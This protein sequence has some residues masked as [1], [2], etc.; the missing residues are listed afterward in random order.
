MTG[1]RNGPYDL[2]RIS[3]Q[4]ITGRLVRLIPALGTLPEGQVRPGFSVTVDAISHTAAI[5]VIDA[6]VRTSIG[7]D[8]DS[9]HI[10]ADSP[11]R[12]PSWG[13]VRRLDGARAHN[14]VREETRHSRRTKDTGVGPGVVFNPEPDPAWRTR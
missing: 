13:V 11:I 14:P 12:F 8:P 10:A 7:S 9:V 4:Q 1:S 5:R 3:M 6:T 2:F